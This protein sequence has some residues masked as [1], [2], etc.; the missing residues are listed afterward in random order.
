[1]HLMSNQIA[2]LTTVR[3]N[4]IFKTVKA[5]EAGFKGFLR[6]CSLERWLPNKLATNF[7]YTCILSMFNELMFFWQVKYIGTACLLALVLFHWKR[8]F[9]KH[10]SSA[11]RRHN[12]TSQNFNPTS[13]TFPKI[14]Y[15]K[16]HAAFF[17]SIWRIADFS[18]NC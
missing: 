10:F 18:Q 8:C 17:L 15:R 2:K 4:L 5:A 9:Y 11:S 6:N 7:V 13:Q 16:R 14:F 12:I 3:T 1:M